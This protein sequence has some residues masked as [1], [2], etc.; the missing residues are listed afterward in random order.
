MMS[1]GSKCRFNAKEQIQISKQIPVIGSQEEKSKIQKPE[2]KKQWQ[3][4]LLNKTKTQNT[5]KHFKGHTQV[6]D[7]CRNRRLGKSYEKQYFTSL[8]A[9]KLLKCPAKTWKSSFLG[10]ARTGDHIG[11]SFQ[12]ASDLNTAKVLYVSCQC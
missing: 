11:L 10:C 7:T 6:D 9:C 12:T 4:N 3:T 2:S 5:R 1:L 8:I